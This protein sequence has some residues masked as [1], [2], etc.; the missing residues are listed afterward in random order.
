MAAGKFARKFLKNSSKTD[1][2]ISFK[3]STGS[4]KRRRMN[5]SIMDREHRQQEIVTLTEDLIAACITGDSSTIAKLCSPNVTTFQQYGSG[6]L[7]KG[8]DFQR[9]CFENSSK[10]HEY[11]EVETTILDPYVHLLDDN[12]ACIA[13]IRSI[14][15]TSLNGR[16]HF[17]QREET[18]VWHQRN[19]QWKNVHFHCGRSIR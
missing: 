9:F 11:S 7:I 16:V 18:C 2:G 6:K 4:I 8:K 5:D 10:N 17:R 3:S 19:G 15:C 12:V 14:K 13:Y 1:D